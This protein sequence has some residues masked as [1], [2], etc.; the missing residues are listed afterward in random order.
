M[1]RSGDLSHLEVRC[2]AALAMHG[3]LWAGMLIEAVQTDGAD[4]GT[5]DGSVMF[6]CRKLIKAGLVRIEHDMEAKAREVR[7]Y[8]I[9][10]EGWQRLRQAQRDLDRICLAAARALTRG[11]E[12]GSP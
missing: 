12:R 5:V 3:R 11:A 2:L 4:A 10:D 9:T 6:T 1:K 7:G 8:A